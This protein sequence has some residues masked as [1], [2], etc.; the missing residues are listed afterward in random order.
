[1]VQDETVRL[2]DREVRACN[3]TVMCVWRRE[4]DLIGKRGPKRWRVETGVK[5]VLIA[6]DW[7]L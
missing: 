7:Q 6:R 1:M 4:I 2:L 5:L 3:M